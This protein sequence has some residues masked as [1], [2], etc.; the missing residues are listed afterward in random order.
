MALVLNW[1][2]KLLPTDKQKDYIEHIL[3]V[4]RSVWNWNLREIKDWIR[5]RSCSI[6]SCSIKHQYILP[7]EAPYPNYYHQAKNLTAAK[8]DHEFLAS[9]PSQ[10][11]Q[12]TL[13][14]LE[15]AINDMKKR[16]FGFPRFKNYYRMR[17]FVYP[18]MGKKKNI[19]TNNQIKL[20]KL[21]WI[22][23]INSRSIPED[24]KIKQARVIRKASGYFVVL[25]IQLD[26]DVPEPIPHGHPVGVD[27]GLNKF[28]AT[29]D[30]LLISRPE[31]LNKLRREIK[32]LQRKLKNKQKNS[33]NR[34]KINAKVARLNQRIT[35]ARKDFHFK[36]A[37]KLCANSGM[38]FVEDINF[39]SWTRGMLRKHF[40]DAAFGNFVTIL[41]WVCSKTDTYFAKVDKNYTS[42]MCPRCNTLTGKKDLSERTHNCGN[43]GYIQN[44]DVAAGEVIRNQGLVAAGLVV[45]LNKMSVVGDLARVSDLTNLVKSRRN[46]KPKS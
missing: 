26:V 23:Y 33:K 43:C 14:T 31:F 24:C 37:H 3:S 4:C 30:G 38:I 13:R 28:A 45:S 11:V 19:L 27:L 42:Q 35:D 21:G 17:S 2:Y 10:V 8:K 34:A 41:K 18:Q 32:L 1:E 12:Q 15:R 29:S 25:A 39:T 36:T 5:S 44:R 20:P 40:V 22:T 16:S 9:A 46:R 7:A 6:N